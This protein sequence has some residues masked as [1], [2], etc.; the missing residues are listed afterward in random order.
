M[1]PYP[2]PDS[3]APVGSGIG[4]AI[5]ELIAGELGGEVR[6]ETGAGFFSTFTFAVP[7][8]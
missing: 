5:V 6:L 3:H 1:A 7:L 2:F 8:L 4:L